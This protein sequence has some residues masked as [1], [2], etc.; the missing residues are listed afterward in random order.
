L[1]RHAHPAA[2]WWRHR[3]RSCPPPV[4]PARSPIPA[5]RQTRATW[6]R[7][8][9]RTRQAGQSSTTATCASA[10][11]SEFVCAV[12]AETD[13]VLQGENIVEEMRLR[14]VAGKLQA[15]QAELAVVPGRR[16]AV[17]LR[18]V[19]AGIGA[20]RSR[21]KPVVAIADIPTAAEAVQA[22]D[23]GTATLAIPVLRRCLRIL[24]IDHHAL[25][26]IDERLAAQDDPGILE[27]TMRRP[28]PGEI[29]QE[30]IAAST[31]A[32]FA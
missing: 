19:I 11:S 20:A 17:P 32:I 16:D 30:Q 29:E 15:Q 25:A 27:G 7:P 2:H 12:G 22:L 5:R 3:H 13:L 14:L 28:L 31:E 18:I 4:P 26:V 6:P 10:Y 1:R 8:A 21:P 24:R 23:V 9:Q